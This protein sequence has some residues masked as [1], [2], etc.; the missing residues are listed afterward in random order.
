MSPPIEDSADHCK[1]LVDHLSL[2]GNDAASFQECYKIAKKGEHQLFSVSE[3][4]IHVR[5]ALAYVS[6]DLETYPRTKTGPT[7]AVS[8]FNKLG[9]DVHN[10]HKLLPCAAR[11]GK[12]V[13][14]QVTSV[15]HSEVL[16]DPPAPTVD[17]YLRSPSFGFVRRDVDGSGACFYF[18]LY[19][20]IE[21]VKGLKCL[22]DEE[23]TDFTGKPL[24]DKQNLPTT[25]EAFAARCREFTA[26]LVREGGTVAEFITHEL[27]QFLDSGQ[28]IPS[29]IL[30]SVAREITKKKNWELLGLGLSGL[31]SHPCRVKGSLIVIEQP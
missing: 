7:M 23:W 29:R 20:A 27:G 12:K 5:E 1:W 11:Y 6:P 28:K 18:C 10:C 24:L 19:D 2:H 17:E 13:P 30:M 15:F 8:Q 9:K 31:S 4:K 26:E 25:P 14:V 16:L 21:S 3:L 22:A